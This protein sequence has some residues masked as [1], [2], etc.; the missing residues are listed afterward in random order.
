MK[1]A[2]EHIPEI[3]LAALVVFIFGVLASAQTTRPAF[4]VGVWAQP[5]ASFPRWKSLGVNVLVGYDGGGNVTKAAWEQAATDAGLWFITEPGTDLASEAKQKLRFGWMQADEPDLNR[6][7]DGQP[8]ADLIPDGR[9]KGWRR[10]EPLATR[11]AA[12]KLAAPSLP[13]FVNFAGPSI[14]PVAY[15]HGDGHKPY[16]AAADLLCM[17]WHIKNA[18]ADRYPLALVGQALDRLKVWSAGKPMWC[19]IEVAQHRYEPVSRG[20][21]P[22]EVEAMIVHAREHGATG[23][24]LFAHALKGGWDPTKRPNG[25]DGIPADIEARL[26]KVLPTLNPTPQPTL[27]D[28]MQRLERIEAKLNSVFR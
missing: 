16:I 19:Y 6:W 23:I 15:T 26:A 12:C 17:D 24:I 22:D 28:V 9:Y 8:N 10:P 14:T 18:N 4:P 7:R 13:V 1:R 5:A 2:I 21:T 11:Y 20:P 3:L 25:W 27:A